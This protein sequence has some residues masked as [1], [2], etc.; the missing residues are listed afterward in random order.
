MYYS[1]PLRVHHLYDG[2]KDEYSRQPRAAGHCDV[3]VAARGQGRDPGSSP[4]QD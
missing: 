1:P 2:E 3:T 4:S